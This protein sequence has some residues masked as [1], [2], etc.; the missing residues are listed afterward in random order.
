MKAEGGSSPWSRLTQWKANCRSR[1][2]A[3]TRH[4]SWC[5][6]EIMRTR[7]LVTSFG[8]AQI[9]AYRPRDRL[10]TKSWNDLMHQ[11]HT[12][13]KLALRNIDYSTCL[14]PFVSVFTVFLRRFSTL[15]NSLEK[16]LCRRWCLGVSS[17]ITTSVWSDGGWKLSRPLLKRRFDFKSY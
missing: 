3:I 12:N 1:L 11:P 6:A 10:T 15:I 5:L 13:L 17:N 4:F 8:T 16:K 14:L 2:T 7:N 9:L